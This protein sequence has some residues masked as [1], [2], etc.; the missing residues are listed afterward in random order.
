MI[1]NV[2]VTKPV[3]E[4][5]RD[6]LTTAYYYHVSRDLQVAYRSLNENPRYCALTNA[7]KDSMDRVEAMLTLFEI[8]EE[9]EE[10]AEEDE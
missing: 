3:L 8:E 4:S 9:G 2:E 5:I 1:E 10:E 6:S 7:L